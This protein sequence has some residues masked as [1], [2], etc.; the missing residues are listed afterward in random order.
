MERIYK[1]ALAVVDQVKP[2]ISKVSES[3]FN[4]GGNGGDD[5]SQS[6]PAGTLTE[7]EPSSDEASFEKFRILSSLPLFELKLF[8]GEPSLLSRGDL[9]TDLKKCEDKALASL[10]LVHM[11]MK[12]IVS[13]QTEVDVQASMKDISLSNE[14]PETK[15]RKSG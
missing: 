13:S 15:K 14:Q 4:F 2:V 1:F 10:K 5:D 7:E 11:D 9:G 6:L 12:V 3:S 8:K